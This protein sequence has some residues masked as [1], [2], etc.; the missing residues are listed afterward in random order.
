VAEISPLTAQELASLLS[1]IYVYA[2]FTPLI[3]VTA[4]AAS[5]DEGDGLLVARLIGRSR[6]GINDV[7]PAT[8]RA[9]AYALLQECE[10]A[11]LLHDKLKGRNPIAPRRVAIKCPAPVSA[12]AL[13]G[14]ISRWRVEAEHAGNPRRQPFVGIRSALNHR[15]A[16]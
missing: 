14:G 13:G 16:S 1:M 15:R 9:R 10:M 7:V 6:N 12:P 2:D 8:E 4:Y 3:R 11:P 5:A